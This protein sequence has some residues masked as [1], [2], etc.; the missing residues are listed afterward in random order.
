M[1]IYK[2]ILKQ[3][4]EKLLNLY[5]LDP[6]S[7]TLGFGD[8]SYWGWKIS[9]FPN[10]TM[11]GGVHA[12]AI[13]LKLSLHSN[14]GFVLN[15]ID[16]VIRA[17]PSIASSKGSLQEAYPR[18]HSFCVT[19]LVAFDVLSAIDRLGTSLNESDKKAYLEI[20]R[21]LIGFITA[22]GE[23]HAIISN[24]LAT[25]IA[26]IVLW[27]KL[28]GDTSN[29]HQELLDIIL[30]HQS[31][32]GWYMEY[33][34]PDPGYQTLCLYY[35]SAALEHWPSEVLKESM[36]K[37]LAF[38][39]ALLHPDHSIGGLYGSRNTE[40]YYPGGL[41][42]MQDMAAT[43]MEKG[44][45]TG[46][47]LLP[48]NIDVGNYCPLLN[49]YAF[50]AWHREKNAAAPMSAMLFQIPGESDF[51]DAG[52]YLKSTPSYF[53]ILNYKKGGVLKVFDLER[54]AMDMEDGGL[55]G[56]LPNG[57][58]FS[59]QSYDKKADFSDKAL[60]PS[61]IQTNASSPSALTTIIV[62]TLSLSFFRSVGFGNFFKKKVVNLL[63]TGKKTVKGSCTRQFHFEADSIRVVET[64]EPDQ[65]KNRVQRLG[66]F[67]S[68]HM[69][70]SGYHMS[71]HSELPEASK[72]VSF[73]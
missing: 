50:A 14:E 40:V 41:V 72:F 49:A 12:L 39:Q 24:H 70:S 73:K 54:R 6:A 42:F 19:A 60:N 2:D 8:R 16:K 4:T 57:K 62:R 28:S 33:E 25:G 38:Q 9:D 67:K 20:V 68:V 45:S 59:T 29:R 32:E 46:V 34:G 23:E 30:S 35:L 21:P 15:V 71:H 7:A 64:I 48:Q 18:E 27:N 69:A 5:D 61:F 55:Y 11:Q 37:A 43:W 47:H 10:A 13:G 66:R 63:M 31:S 44:I 26:A 17:I 53:A 56:T 22:N 36:E 1:N 3:N 58:G 52:I 51:K 65:M